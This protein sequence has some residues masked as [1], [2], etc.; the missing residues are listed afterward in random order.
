M[1]NRVK[2]ALSSWINLNEVLMEMTE[3]ELEKALEIERKADK[4]REQ[5][6]LILHRRL[7]KLQTQRERETLLGG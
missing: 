7:K 1:S 4:P 5:H 6:L 3:S 2:Q